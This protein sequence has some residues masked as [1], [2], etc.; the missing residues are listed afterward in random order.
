MK[1]IFFLFVISFLISCN[2]PVEQHSATAL[3]NDLYKEVQNGRFLVCTNGSH[4]NEYDDQ[5]NYFSGLIQFIKEVDNGS[6]VS[7]K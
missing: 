1:T 6:F 3:N 4:I 2:T 7:K 5:K